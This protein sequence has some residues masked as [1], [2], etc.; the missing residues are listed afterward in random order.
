MVSDIKFDCVILRPLVN[1][2]VG[3]SRF[4]DTHNDL[5]DPSNMESIFGMNDTLSTFL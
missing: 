1:C 5:Y 2:A 4:Y 3:V